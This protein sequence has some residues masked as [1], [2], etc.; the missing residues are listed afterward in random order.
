MDRFGYRHSA[1]G[2]FGSDSLEI[3]D[4]LLDDSTLIGELCGNKIP[5]SIQSSQNH[6][7]MK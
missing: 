5:S 3:R 7:W 6:L 4:G 2:L 1:C